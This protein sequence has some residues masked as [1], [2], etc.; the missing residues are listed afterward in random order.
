MVSGAGS[1]DTA[2]SV[3]VPHERTGVR[4]ARHAVADRLESLGVQQADRADAMLV[5]SELVS[6]SVR[7]ADPLSGG[8]INVRWSVAADALHLA[9]TDGGARTQP[10][11]GI[12]ALSATG[13]RGLDIVRSVSRQW[14]VTE[15]ESS[16]TVWVELPRHPASSALA[17]DQES[18][19]AD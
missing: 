10:R 6:N 2:V 7:H 18:R 11:A 17:Q 16:V 5:V 13:G 12:A 1:S 8:E 4:M 15:G 19:T 14:G 3:S 9:I